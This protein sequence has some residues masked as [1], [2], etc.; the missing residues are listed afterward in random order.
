[1]MIWTVLLDIFSFVVSCAMLALLLAVAYAA[2][3]KAGK[4]AAHLED[5]DKDPEVYMPHTHGGDP[6]A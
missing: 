4:A 3:L 1:M 6:D 2:G 5:D